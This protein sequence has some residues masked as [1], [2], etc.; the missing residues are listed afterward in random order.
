MIALVFGMIVYKISVKVAM[1]KTDASVSI[2][3]NVTT[4]T[5]A[6]INLIGIYILSYIY[7]IVAIKLTDLGISFV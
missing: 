2:S 4:V 1:I 5:A 6:I 3:S 7:S